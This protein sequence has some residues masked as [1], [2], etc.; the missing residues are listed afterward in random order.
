VHLP[1]Q[2]TCCGALDLHDGDQATATQLAQTN[3]AAFAMP[4]LEAILTIASGC[5][6]QLQAYNQAGF[7]NKV[8]D[9]SDF[10]MPYTEHLNGLLA[11]LPAT[12]CLHTP[13]SLKNVMR[14][15]QGALRLL[16]QLPNIS[17]TKLPDTLPCCGSA[18]GYMLEHPKMAKRLLNGVLDAA[19][20]SYQ[21]NYLAS[22]N[23]GC[24]LHIAAG[25]RERGIALEVVH[26]I[27]LIARQLK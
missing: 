25:L 26:P 8:S 16:Q 10:L 12:V 23:I 22:S 19:L 17:I 4:S 11:P 13:C 2:Q 5:G 18:G 6:S 21:P 24:A 3:C 7:A 27:T 15:E 9:I 20:G 1:E 14:A